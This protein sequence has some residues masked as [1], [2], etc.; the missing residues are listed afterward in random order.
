MAVK[1]LCVGKIPREVDLLCR[2]KAK[3]A[4]ISVEIVPD[5]PDKEKKTAIRRES[6]A[7]LG[8]LENADRVFLFDVE[9]TMRFS[10]ITL[11]RDNV[12]IIG[13]SNGVDERVKDCAYCR[14]SLSPL[15][16]PHALFRLFALELLASIKH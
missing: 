16:Y 14:I 13:G 10:D 8:K 15:T 11:A 3:E 9:G 4:G 2:Q 1:L 12:F 7:I 5:E 6:D